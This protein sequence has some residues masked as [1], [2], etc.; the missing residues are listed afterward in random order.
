M[1]AGDFAASKACS[2]RFLDYYAREPWIRHLIWLGGGSHSRDARSPAP[3][4][5]G[6]AELKLGEHDAA[7]RHLGQSIEADP[8]NPLPFF[9]LGKMAQAEGDAAEAER[10]LTE[11]RR[12]GYARCLGDRIVRSS[13]NRFAAI[14]G[15]GR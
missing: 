6:A 7:K 13:Q 14:D 3:T 10:C 8:L 12:L 11:A 9:N 15:R 1:N 2:E 5:L 4:N